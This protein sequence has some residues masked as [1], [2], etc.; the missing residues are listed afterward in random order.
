MQWF[1]AWFGGMEISCRSMR[2]NLNQ[3]SQSRQHLERSGAV[4]MS[5]LSGVQLS[6]F[7]SPG[8]QAFSNV[9]GGSSRLMS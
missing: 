3:V 1:L 5:S 6:V 8:A 4:G 7:S 9:F 2:R